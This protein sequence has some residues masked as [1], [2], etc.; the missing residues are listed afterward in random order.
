M[1]GSHRSVLAFVVA[2]GALLGPA[3]AASAQIVV[4]PNSPAGQEYALPTEKAR[5]QAAGK[6][7]Y[8]ASPSAGHTAPIFGQGV[9]PTAKR[10]GKVTGEEKGRGAPGGRTPLDDRNT[11]AHLARTPP[12]LSSGGTDPTPTI[13]GIA[14]AVLLLASGTFLLLRRGGA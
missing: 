1:V 5:Q 11:A 14:A 12:S 3:A 9:T 10:G 7:D 2:V 4:D 13:I 8:N 6:D